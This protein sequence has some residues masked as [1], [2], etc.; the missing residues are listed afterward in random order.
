MYTMW[1]LDNVMA[2]FVVF[3]LSIYFV[4]LIV[5]AII[6]KLV[7]WVTLAFTKI[8]TQ[9]VGMLERLKSMIAFGMDP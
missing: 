3:L 8:K 5:R 1:Q 6:M 9:G 4:I 7:E 2:I